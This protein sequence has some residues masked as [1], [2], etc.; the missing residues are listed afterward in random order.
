MSFSGEH[1]YVRGS[2]GTSAGA[3]LTHPPQPPSTRPQPPP[4][5]SSPAR[6]PRPPPSPA[7]SAARSSARGCARAPH[8]RRSGP[9]GF[10][11]RTNTPARVSS[12]HG[13]GVRRRPHAYL[14]GPVL[15]R[16]E[17]LS[18]LCVWGN[19]NEVS[20]LVLRGRR[21]RRCK[22]LTGRTLLRYHSGS[23][24]C[25]SATMG[26]KRYRLNLKTSRFG[27]PMLASCVVRM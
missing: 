8:A 26:T 23:P 18:V 19:M 10:A 2:A 5:L 22:A 3:E 15:G 27:P 6:P 11:A 9:S 21:R 4:I 14:V 1:E 12:A 20:G 25:S 24:K 16:E 13:A 7:P 17:A